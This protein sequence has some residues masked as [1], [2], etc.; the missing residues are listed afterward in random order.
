MNDSKAGGVEMLS[1]NLGSSSNPYD[2]I[3]VGGGL[4]GLIA[5][6]NALR[7]NAKIL[8][9][10]GRNRLGGQ[11]YNIKYP[12]ERRR[13]HHN[14]LYQRQRHDEISDND[15]DNDDNDDDN[16]DYDHDDHHHYDDVSNQFTK[17]KGDVNASN[18]DDDDDYLALGAESLNPIFHKHIIKEFDYYDIDY[19]SE[20]KQIDNNQ[21]YFVYNIFLKNYNIKSMKDIQEYL[22]SNFLFKKI[23]KIIESDLSYITFQDGYHQLNEYIQQCYDMSYHDYILFRLH[24]HPSS[25]GG[26]SNNNNNNNNGDDDIKKK[27]NTNNHDSLI[28]DYLLLQGYLLTGG[29]SMIQSALQI[30]LILKGFRNVVQ[31]FSLSTHI[32]D[33]NFSYYHLDKEEEDSSNKNQRKYNN[34]ITGK[35]NTTMK[36]TSISTANTVNNNDK[37]SSSSSSFSSSNTENILHRYPKSLTKLINKLYDDIISKGGQIEF[38][39]TVIYIKAQEIEREQSEFRVSNY[40]YPKLSYYVRKIFIKFADELK[41]IEYCSKSAILAVPTKCLTSIQFQPKLPDIISNSIRCNASNNNTSMIK[42]YTLVKEGISKYI[43]RINTFNYEIKDCYAVSYSNLNSDSN[44]NRQRRSNIYRTN[45]NNS[46]NDNDYNNNDQKRS[47][48]SRSSNR[49]KEEKNNNH[50]HNHRNHHHL[51]PPSHIDDTQLLCITGLRDELLNNILRKLKKI[52]PDIILESFH[53]NSFRKEYHADRSM[54][55]LII[56]SSSSPS[57]YTVLPESGSIYHDFLS[58]PFTRGGWFTLRAGMMIHDADDDENDFDDD[59]DAYDEDDNN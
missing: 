25:S 7:F 3:I 1:D 38:K 53:D 49:E 5:A 2:V 52:H 35:D 14:N 45:K 15:D 16:D 23:I 34:I 41:Q 47:S 44:H 40:D 24:V 8:I 48:S 42:I 20:Q 55:P 39:K 37:S 10:E 11:I 4:T 27:N 58:D 13:Y 36:V 54:M 57:V 6:R 51:P 26:S 50:H 32:Y 28:Y 19:K 9:L 59:D 12:Y 46:K 56:S 17:D 22:N 33:N 29:N 21:H 31:A 18:D 30:L 43:Q